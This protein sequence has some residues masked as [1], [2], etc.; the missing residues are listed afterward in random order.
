MPQWLDQ[1]VRIAE[2]SYRVQSLLLRQMICGGAERG[3]SLKR[4]AIVVA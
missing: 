2:P 3:L 4:V 1:Y